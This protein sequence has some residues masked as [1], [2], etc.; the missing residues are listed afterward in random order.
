MGD[1]AVRKWKQTTVSRKPWSVPASVAVILAML[2]SVGCGEPP[3]PTQDDPR[4]RP[5]PE[6]EQSARG[7][8]VHLAMW[9][10]DPAIN[11]YMREFVTPRLAERHG[12][13]LDIVPAQADIPALL[14]AELAAGRATSAYDLLWINGENF[15]KLRDLGALYGPFTDLLPNNSF[16]DWANP[17]IARDFQQDV[18]GME[19]PWGTVQLLLIAD[20]ARVTEPPTDVAALAAWIKAHPGRFTI[21]RAFT[22][23]SFLKTLMIALAGQP[24]ALDGP[25]DESR[26]LEARDRAFAWL[27]DVR[28]A[29]WRE[30]RSF[31]RGVGELH[32]LFANGE[33]DFT[34]SM[35]DGEVDN[36]VANG[37]FP[38]SAYAY[39]LASGTLANT[40]YLGIPARAGHKAA[41]L[42]VVNEL[43][44]AEAQFE[45]QRP[46]VWG[47]GTVLDVSRLPAPW[48]ARFAAANE[49]RH[50]PP[51]DALATRALAEP[52]PEVMIRLERD[53]RATFLAD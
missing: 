44:S 19:A 46:E 8:T 47:D 45:K 43:Q 39:A 15:Y 4:G 20:R 38:D 51:R 16:V 28:P 26:Y 49:R 6:I 42:T 29:L 2:L 53:F 9:T 7:A 18:A 41:A 40:H 48:P 23:L 21:D 10:G 3:S 24:T 33:V 13:T 17:R 11:R 14:A 1:D 32:Q 37:L 22:G 52:S 31:P 25:F 5:W 36:K 30:G 27:H 34:M 12:I 50:A 35:N